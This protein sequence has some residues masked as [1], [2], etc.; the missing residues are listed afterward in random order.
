MPQSSSAVFKMLFDIPATLLI[1]CSKHDR[2][3]YF[4]PSQPSVAFHIET[5]RLVYTA[6]QMA[7]FYMKCNKRMKWVNLACWVLINGWV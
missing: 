3:K 2:K 5:S 1:K 4:N 7:G 6:N